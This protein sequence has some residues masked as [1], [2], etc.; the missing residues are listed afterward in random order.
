MNSY[1][2]YEIVIW[3]PEINFETTFYGITCAKDYTEAARTIDEWY[4]GE[5]VVSLKLTNWGEDNIVLNFS[6]ETLEK[7]KSEHIF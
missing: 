3:D 2:E 6:K 5:D 4:E 7:I 1:Y